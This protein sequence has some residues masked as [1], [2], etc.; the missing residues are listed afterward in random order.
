MSAILDPGRGPIRADNY[1]PC[2]PDEVGWGWLP[3][4]ASTPVMTIGSGESVTL[5]TLSHEGILADQGRDPRTFLG[6]HGVRDVLEDAVE[7]AASEVPNGD[8]DG[9]HV[10]TGPIAVTGARPGDVLRVDVRAL[11]RRV[12]YGF[13]SNR[14]GFGA[15]PGEYPLDDRHPWTPDLLPGGGVSHFCWVEDSG[16]GARGRFSV[17]AGRTASFQLAP[18]LGLMGVA[19]QDDAPV[20]SVPPGPH[21]GNIDIKHLVA[22]STLYLPIRADG[23]LFYAGDPHFA[24][25]NGEVAL[26]ALEASLRATLTLTV[27]P[28][29]ESTGLFGALTTPLAETTE[30]WIPTG[31]AASL[32]E[33]M[34]RAVREAIRFLSE[35]FELPPQSA[36][37]YLSAA[38]DFE[39]SQVVDGV[40]GVHCLIPKRDWSSW[41]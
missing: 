20:H 2:R 30:H 4:A 19:G 1:L 31:M 39:V 25:G 41:H 23:A 13:I 32:D 17:G 40:V 16:D 28:A 11:D 27:I 22:G 38:G 6:T 36:L 7:L 21:G 24:Q 3:T 18:F 9:P 14:H 33:A 12:P 35:R 10:V 37:A 15:L 29:D 26:T 34:R 5:D 8:E